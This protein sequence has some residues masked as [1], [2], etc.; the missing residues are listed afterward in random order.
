MK[1]VPER[2]RVMY[3]CTGFI[4]ALFSSGSNAVIRYVADLLTWCFVEH[5]GSQNLWFCAAEALDHQEADQSAKHFES[6]PLTWF[7][8]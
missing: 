3:F 1:F 6:E 4:L 2:P 7:R 5:V 8:V